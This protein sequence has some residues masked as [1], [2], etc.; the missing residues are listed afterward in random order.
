MTAANNLIV[1]WALD[2][3]PTG[4]T[5]QAYFASQGKGKNF[6]NIPPLQLKAYNTQASGQYGV[7]WS[8]CL[9]D[10]D[11]KCPLG[12]H[13]IGMVGHGK[14][15]DAD[16][17]ATS[18]GCKG[19]QNRVLCIPNSMILNSCNWHRDN[20]GVSGYDLFAHCWC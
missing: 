9:N 4:F 1:V 3:D 15:F 17:R 19:K 8:P 16:R 18:S 5:S 10:K 7:V 12:Y 11:R 2:L 20:K 13:D 14:V 6:N